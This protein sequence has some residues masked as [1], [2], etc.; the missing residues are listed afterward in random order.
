MAQEG[1]PEALPT[2]TETTVHKVFVG[3]LSFQTTEEGLVKCFE[4]AGKVL[5]ADIITRGRRSI[6]YGFVS[7]ATAEEAEKAT[8]ELNKKELDGREINVEIARPKDTER[9]RRPRRTGRRPSHRRRSHDTDEEEEGGQTAPAAEEKNRGRQGRPKRRG[10]GR[11]FSYRRNISRRPMEKTE[12][13]KITLF[14]GNLPWSTTDETL[15]DLFNDYHVKSARIARFGSRSKG[16]GFVELESEEDQKKA[17]EN[18]KNIVLEGRNIYIKVALFPSQQKQS[19]EA[20]LEDKEQP[21][22]EEKE[23][24]DTENTESAENTK[25]EEAKSAA[26]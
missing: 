10:R 20:Q 8:K 18:F 15:Q 19:E 9:P 22:K 2:D 16:Y 6:G 12:A 17:L 26:H 24:E 21:K 13:S 1:S 14:V 25:E 3:N 7:F 23:K 4:D 5:G 11:R